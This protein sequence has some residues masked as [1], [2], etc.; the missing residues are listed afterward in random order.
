MLFLERLAEQKIQ[1][2]ILRGELD[3]L[4]G[5]GKPIPDETGMELLAPELRTAYRLLK[6]AGYI[7]EE[8][9]VLKEIEDVVSLLAAKP[10]SGDQ[11]AG[12]LRLRLL[13]QRLGEIRSEQIWMADTYCLRIAEKLAAIPTSGSAKQAVS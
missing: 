13:M 10:D 2:A 8:V 11:P 5:R 9:R 1:Q 6:N 12:A 7:P 3:R 4:T